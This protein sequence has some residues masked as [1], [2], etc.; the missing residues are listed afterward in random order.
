MRVCGEHA[1]THMQCASTKLTFRLYDATVQLFCLHC[2]QV[3]LL[4]HET[5][6][7]SSPD[8][9]LAIYCMTL[10]LE[11]I[12]YC[13]TSWRRSSEVKLHTRIGTSLLFTHN[14]CIDRGQ[15]RKVIKQHGLF[16][17]SAVDALALFHH[18]QD[19]YCYSNSHVILM[20]QN[21]IYTALYSAAGHNLY[22]HFT[23]PFPF[24]GSGSGL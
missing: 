8:H 20:W 24:C 19:C 23:R 16:T 5:H 14:I 3:P 7:L 6:L 13:S 18:F 9:I 11:R 17:A 15:K 22:M 21:V 12:G 2:T 4:C 10:Y 1:W